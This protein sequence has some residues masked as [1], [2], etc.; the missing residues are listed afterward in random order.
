MRAKEL[1]ADQAKA[2]L[3]RTYAETDLRLQSTLSAD[4]YKQYQE[5]TREFR[6]RS[7]RDSFFQEGGGPRGGRS[8]RGGR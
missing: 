4:Q 8:G 5:R 6:E 7:L 2:E 3:E 1:T